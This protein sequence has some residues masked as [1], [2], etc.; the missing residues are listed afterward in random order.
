MSSPHPDSTLAEIRGGR[1]RSHWMWYVFPQLAGLGTSATAQRYAIAS[2]GEAAAYL[3]HPVLG[4]R[5][6]E[7]AEA[8]LALEQRSAHDIFG[9]P[10]ELKLRSSVTLFALA[11]PPGSVFDRV[12]DAYFDGE[13]DAKTLRLLGLPEGGE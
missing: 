8:L 12:L 4:S 10:D 6:L 2:L 11:S 3:H 13:R 1:K 5:L 7:C 9:W